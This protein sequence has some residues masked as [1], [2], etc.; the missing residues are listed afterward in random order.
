M[1]YFNLTGLVAMSTTLLAGPNVT[2]AMRQGTP[3]TSIN[4]RFPIFCV[5]IIVFP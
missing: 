4:N 1:E 2:D 5:R 3:A